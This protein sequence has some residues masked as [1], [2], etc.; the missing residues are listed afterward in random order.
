VRELSPK[1]IKAVA[2][3]FEGNSVPAYWHDAPAG[4]PVY[5]AAKGAYEGFDFALML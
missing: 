1:E 5:V 3:E 4:S 2:D